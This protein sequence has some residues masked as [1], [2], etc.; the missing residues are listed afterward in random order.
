LAVT[1]ARQAEYESNER[2]MGIERASRDAADFFANA[3]N[4][5]GDAVDETG[6]PGLV[7]EID[8]LFVILERREHPDP[9]SVVVRRTVILVA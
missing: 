8:R 4:G 3:E 6:T 9:Y 2:A 7:L 5:G 1:D